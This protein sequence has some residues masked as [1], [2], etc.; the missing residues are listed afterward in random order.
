[1]KRNCERLE[2]SSSQTKRSETSPVENMLGI[3]EPKWGSEHF[4]S[5]PSEPKR[6]R[7]N[8][9][10]PERHVLGV[11]SGNAESPLETTEP[12]DR[13][14]SSRPQTGIM[15]LPPEIFLSVFSYLS[16][17][18]LCACV[19]PVC[20]RWSILSKQPCL[21]KAL[22]FNG[23]AV[24]T[25]KVCGLLQRS[26]Q[27]RKLTLCR[28]QDTDAVLKQLL[29]T[30]KL[31]ERIEMCSCRGSQQKKE[32]QGVTLSEIVKGSTKLCSI[33]ITETVVTGSSFYN[34]LG[35]HHNR[36]KS[37]IMDKGMLKKYLHD[38]IEGYVLS[39]HRRAEKTT[40]RINC[41]YL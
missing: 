21:W 26:P 28:R 15:E 39:K 1:M 32:V 10:S 6:R 14:E 37:L 35:Q 22:T 3:H 29:R 13:I 4:K 17:K 23:N 18:E 31:I 20:R 41:N 40:C 7:S 11:S 9:E 34:A 38:F 24:T 19:A 36:F 25:R 33:V 27:L 16:V 30:N 8:A 5:T 2:L 12:Q